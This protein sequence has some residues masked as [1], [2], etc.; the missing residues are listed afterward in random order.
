[1]IRIKIPDED[2]RH[3]LLAYLKTELGQALIRRGRSGSVIDHLTVADVEA[4]PVPVFADDVA[5]R[6]SALVGSAIEDRF[7]GRS[8]L[9][10][11]MADLGTDLPIPNTVLSGHVAWTMRARDFNGRFDAGFHHPFVRESRKQISSKPSHRLGDLVEAVLP[12]RYKRYYVEREHGRPILSGRQ[13]LQPEPVNLRFV[14]DRSFRNPEDY[15]VSKGTV[16]FGAVGRS[17]GR[18]A[19]PALVTD[20]RHGW[21]AS[22]DVMRL[23]PRP[24]VPPGLVWLAVAV[25]QVQAQIKAL[26]FGSVVDHMNPWDVEDVIVPDIGAEL[27]AE[28]E[29]AWEKFARSTRAIQDATAL[30]ESALESM[31]AST[32]LS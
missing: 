14:S 30:T 25:P 3:V 24:N 16:V 1:M 21:L 10:R 29:D 20:D 4:V 13:L 19:W 26:S 9:N 15:E 18:Q 17:E 11:V 5:T 23:V 2:Q 31:A 12:L 27:V 6:I 22:N 8:S 32:G 28:V 7:E